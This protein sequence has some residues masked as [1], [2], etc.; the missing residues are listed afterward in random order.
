LTIVLS[1]HLLVVVHC[2]VPVS[3]GVILTS[4][5]VCK[6]G[7]RG[8]DSTKNQ[9]WVHLDLSRMEK[10][11]VS[12]PIREGELP[13]QWLRFK[14]E[15]NQFLTAVGKADATSA[16][17]TV[18]FLRA[19]GPRVND[20]YETMTFTETED[21]NDFRTVV[22]KLDELC[23]KRTSKHVI[24][25]KVFQLKQEGRTIICSWQR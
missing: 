16:V 19:A 7:V 4:K 15:F 23:T 14:K 25:D 2:V 22:A 6:H 9:K 1:P 5:P 18:I 8:V 17:K 3:I 10:Y 13:E 12:E 20:M 24:R 21:K 11:L